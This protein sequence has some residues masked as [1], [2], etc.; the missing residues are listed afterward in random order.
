AAAGDDGGGGAG[1]AGRR[2]HVA[3]T[4]RQISLPSRT[5]SRRSASTRLF[6][7]SHRKTKRSGRPTH[8]SWAPMK[9][10]VRVVRI[11]SVLAALST[12]CG[13]SSS[14]GGEGTPDANS[15]G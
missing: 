7:L 5:R 3:V 10:E 13:G 1:R 12:A 4:S 11:V 9:F 14:G 15:M 8:A 6:V 2:R